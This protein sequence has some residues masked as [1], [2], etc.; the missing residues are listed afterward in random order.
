[1]SQRAFTLIEV[2]VVIAIIAIL[3]A[4][5]LPQ[6]NRTTSKQYTYKVTY[7]NNDVEII[8]AD[9]YYLHEGSIVFWY[10]SYDTDKIRSS[11]KSIEEIPPLAEKQD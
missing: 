10:Y 5:I 8:V 2:L 11:Y 9:G 1:M 6:I 7:I 4:L 3:A